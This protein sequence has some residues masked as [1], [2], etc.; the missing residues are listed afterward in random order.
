MRTDHAP[1][2]TLQLALWSLYQF[3][4]FFINSAFIIHAKE[5]RI[6]RSKKIFERKKE[7]N[8]RESRAGAQRRLIALTPYPLRPVSATESLIGS[9]ATTT[10]TCLPD[11]KLF[12]E[13]NLINIYV[14]RILF[15]N[16]LFVS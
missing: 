13:K 2:Q 15:I 5:A 7:R 4:F 12:I 6:R 16:F 3:F 8:D 14:I 11:R 9:D 1:S 10:D